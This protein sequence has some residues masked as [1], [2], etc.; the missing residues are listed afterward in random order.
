MTSIISKLPQVGTTIFTTMS[1]LAA[2]VG[3][4]N[5]SQGFPDY[6]CAPE[7]IELV[8]KAM[9]DGHNQYAPMAGVKALRD[10]IA[11]KTKRLYNADY[12][13]DTEITVTAGATQAL[14]TAICAVIN[15]N[16]EVIVFE[17]AFDSYAPAIKLMGGI[18]KSLELEP[19]NNYRIDWGMVK[20]LINNRTKLIILNSPHNPTA[21]ILHQEDIE[22]LSAIVKDQDILILSD[23][24]YEHLIYDGEIHQSMARYPELQ[25]RSLIVASFGKLFHAT[26]WKVGYCLAPAYLMQEFKKI[27]QF[28]VFSVNSAMQYA[29]AEYLKDENTYLN[30]P[31]FFQE[32][33]DYF[34][35]GLAET[36][37]ELLPSYGSYFQ[38]VKY[39][40]LTDEADTDFALR[41][42]K[43]AG[44]ACIPTSV[45]YTQGTDHHVLRF[46]FAKKQETLDDAV[47]RLI[48]FKL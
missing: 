31:A 3:A 33:R 17:P 47:N 24:V 19:Y 20:K 22:E 2:D 30:L 5:L 29:I 14:F 45:F 13:P 38:S 26:G 44:V 23:E 4:I 42:I 41:L 18:V 43:D 46:C 16:D 48:D 35:K 25:Q 32:K 11:Y 21:T 36:K 28:L 1:A 40:H 6:D 8:N 10:Q 9:K 7:L 39:G 15:P 34:R 37:F 27:H 12:D